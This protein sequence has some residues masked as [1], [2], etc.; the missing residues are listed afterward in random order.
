MNAA[1]RA[2]YGLVLPLA[3]LAAGC[4]DDGADE[5]DSGEQTVRIVAK[6]NDEPISET[7]LQLHILRRTGE[8][9]DRVDEEQ[10]ETL[11]LELVEMTLIAQDARERGLTD[12]ETVRAQMRN[13]QYAVLAQ[14]MLEELKREPVPNDEMLARFDQL[15]DQESQRQEYH[16][17]HILLADE[18]EAEAVI[19]ELDDGE[20][21]GALAERL[22]RGPTAVRG[23][24]LGWF[25]PGDMVR[26]FGEAVMELEVGEYTREPVRTR[27][28]YH[29]I[30]LEGQ[31]DREPP[32]F[33]DV[34]EQLRHTLTQ[35][36]IEGYVNNLRQEG[37]V[38]LYRPRDDD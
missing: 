34:S 20:A 3:L 21:F 36:R 9:P 14:A 27:Y 22:S 28:G 7:M 16:A 15:M 12:N 6:V 11:L 23:G 29:V 24:D 31:R 35:E 37:K 2:L 17:R 8:N 10:R 26:P 13:L 33:E 30:K 4:S 25:V 38:E 5:Q 18:S 19:E 32:H 1:V